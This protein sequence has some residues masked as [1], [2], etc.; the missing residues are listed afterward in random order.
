MV[1]PSNLYDAL[2]VGGGPAGATAALVM[3]RAGL[4]VVVLERS[5]FPRFYLGESL[6]PRNMP[7]L[8]ELG[9]D[10]ALAAI[11]R[12]EKRG[13]ELEESSA[14]F[15][16]LV[17]HYYDHSFRELLLEGKGPLGV[18]R[19]VLSVLAGNVFPRP[20]FSLRWRLR[21]L[22]L[23][24]RLHRRFPLVTRRERFSLLTGPAREERTPEETEAFA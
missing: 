21:L 18:H 5:Q 9:L 7:L 2:V 13:A 6:L 22:E 20:A 10:G 12:V 1:S 14:P 17:E 4:Q 16:R 15:F 19:A 11:P 8:R 3:A 24:V 23:F